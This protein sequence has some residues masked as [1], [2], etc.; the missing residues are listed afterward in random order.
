M[1]RRLGRVSDVRPGQSRCN[2]QA[3]A[4]QIGASSILDPIPGAMTGRTS[5]FPHRTLV[6]PKPR[7]QSSQRPATI[8]RPPRRAAHRPPRT[9]RSRFPL[10]HCPGSPI[11]SFSMC[12]WR[13][14]RGGPQWLVQTAS[15]TTP[16]RRTANV[17]DS[18]SPRKANQRSLCIT[19]QIPPPTRMADKTRG[20]RARSG[21]PARRTVPPPA[22]KTL[23]R[24]AERDQ[25]QA[26]T[27]S[28]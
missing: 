16:R 22:V 27:L 11:I 8:R 5:T 6:R 2:E 14:T 4:N 17:L 10:G 9:V 24:R 15:A 13:R 7:L 20:H 19:D 28:T 12:C 3:G 26:A 23:A 21:V 18:P 25:A 1:G